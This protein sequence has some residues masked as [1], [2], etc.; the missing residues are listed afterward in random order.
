MVAPKDNTSEFMK[1]QHTKKADVKNGGMR[2]Q[3]GYG[4]EHHQPSF[5]RAVLQ[6]HTSLRMNV[7]GSAVFNWLF[8]FAISNG[9][10]FQFI[11]LICIPHEITVNQQQV[12]SIV[13][14][15]NNRTPTR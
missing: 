8:C 6:L 12:L 2:R 1:S 11:F 7:L 9:I 5:R 15:F 3:K 10:T 13:I 14:V 4:M